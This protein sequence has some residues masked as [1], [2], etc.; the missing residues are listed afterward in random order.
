MLEALPQGYA[1]ALVSDHGF[2]KVDAEVNLAA[3]AAKH[4]VAG[5]R[6]MGSV[7]VAETEAA[8]SFLRDT[9]EDSRYGIGR[10]IPKDEL[11]RFA[12]QYNAAIAVFESAPGFLFGGDP[13][14]EIFSKPR[15]TGNHGHWPT[16]YRSVFV[17]WGQGIQKASLPE[18]SIKE[19]A[20][21]L[22]AVL[23]VKL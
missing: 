15:E 11:A 8:A 14:G 18:F 9:A 23:G 21:K 10:T 6:A 7:A 17:L 1:V 3:L 4:G 16:R 20:G 13:K 2:E 19:I 5:V 12:P 22:A